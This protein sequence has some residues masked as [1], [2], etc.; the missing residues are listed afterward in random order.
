MKKLKRTLPIFGLSVGI[1]G[2]AS[3][4]SGGVS[5]IV[6][7]IKKDEEII[8]NSRITMASAVSA[9]SFGYADI[10]LSTETED[11]KELENKIAEQAEQIKSLENKL[12]S[13]GNLER[14]V[15]YLEKKIEKSENQGLS[16]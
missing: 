10:V 16:K 14:K 2:L 15:E 7:E 13:I 4:V 9:M 11:N 5:W 6:G 8:Q 12:E 3:L 1:L